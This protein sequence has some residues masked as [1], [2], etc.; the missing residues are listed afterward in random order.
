MKNTNP[1]IET[2]NSAESALSSALTC[3]EGTQTLMRGLVVLECVA[4]GM[5]DVKSI[6]EYL[7]IPRSTAH[8][9]LSSLVK[10]NYLRHAGQRTYSLGHRLIGLG[11]RAKEQ[12]P[13]IDIAR[14][15][16]VKLSMLTGD[17]LHLGQAEGGEVFYL[18]KLNGQRG[19]EMRSRV[20]YRMPL[21]STG[22]GKAL[23]V[24]MPEERWK[25]LYDQASMRKTNPH[26]LAR[27][28]PW[29]EYTRTMRVYQQQGWVYDMEENEQGIRCI[30]S[31]IRDH[32][33]QVVAAI[34]LA[35]ATIF[36]PTSRMKQLGP[37]VLDT[38]RTISR[39][40]GWSANL[41]TRR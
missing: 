37:V 24:D 41:R 12:M 21:A 14:Q 38:A 35:S 1:V 30:A 26:N 17:T 22:V 25:E 34:S 10:S 13:L 5:N 9:V 2:A 36:M 7:D 39:E 20:G 8:R 27:M 23:M 4:Q 6:S 33:N 29:E 28:L 40:L 3:V 19:L 11:A 18:D 16:L 31:P 32:S 15:A